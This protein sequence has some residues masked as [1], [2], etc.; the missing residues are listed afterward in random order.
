MSILLQFASPRKKNGQMRKTLSQI[1][2]N[3]RRCAFSTSL[4][5]LIKVIRP[6]QRGHRG[7]SHQKISSR[8]KYLPPQH[9]YPRSDR[10]PLGSN[11]SRAKHREFLFLGRPHWMDTSHLSG[12]INIPLPKSRI[13]PKETQR[14]GICYV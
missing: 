12:W 9:C 5:R 6:R 8:C 10:R 13:N 11:D 4:L 1:S 3:E 2:P 7:L 14:F